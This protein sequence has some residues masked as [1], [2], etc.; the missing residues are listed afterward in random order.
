M[1]IGGV[2]GICALALALL[3][4]MVP[5]GCVCLFSPKDP[6]DVATANDAT[7]TTTIY[8]GCGCLKCH[9]VGCNN[10]HCQCY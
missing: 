1:T 8:K 6:D 7:T 2:F 9:R 3:S 5:I 4:C 10:C